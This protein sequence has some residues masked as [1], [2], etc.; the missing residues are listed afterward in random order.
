MSRYPANIITKNPATPTGPSAYGSAPGIWR[1]DEVA[2]WVKQGVWPNANIVPDTYFPYVSLLL[3]TTSLSNAN[4]NLFVD[5]SGAFNPI[6]RFGNTTQGS[7]SPYSTTWS[8]YF[9]GS[10]DWLSLASTSQFAIATSSTPFT[11][12]GWIYPT[13]A[14]SC[15]FTDAYTGGGD[16]IPITIS[17]S[18]GVSVDAISGRYVALG[19]F[20]GSAWV[21]AA[22]ANSEVSLNMWTHIACVFTG[23]TFKIYYNGVDV[24]AA[25]AGSSWGMTGNSGSAWYIGRRWDIA[26]NDYFTGYISNLRFVNGTA[27]YTSAFTPPTTPLTAIT[28]T[29]LLTCQSNRFRD[30]STNNLTITAN[31]NSSVTD[32]SPF[33]PTPP[34]IS[35]NQSDIT[36]W[37]GYFDGS[38][39]LLS[40]PTSSALG[41]TSD[42]TVET[43]VY[44][45]SYAAAA[46]AFFDSRAAGT[47]CGLYYSL[48]S[49]TGGP[50]AVGYA[51]NSALVAV[52]TF[53]IPLFAWTH[54]AFTR[55]G[56]TIT[57]YINGTS[58]FTYTD[59]R[60]FASSTNYD[61]G[62]S[63]HPPQGYMAGYRVV[64]GTAVYTGNF[65]PPT[66]PLTAV[67]GTSLLTMQ[68][69]AFTDRSTNNLV[70]SV[71][72]NPTV[73]GNSPFNTVGYWSNYFDGNADFLD[74]ALPSTT[75][76]SSW[77]FECW[78]YATATNGIVFDARPN[79][80]NGY[81]PLIYIASSTQ[82]SFAYNAADNFITISGGTLNRWL[83]VAVVKNGSNVS[84]YVNGTSVYSVS[85]SN[86]WAIGASRPRI[87]A[88]GGF[89]GAAQ[90]HLTG[91][92]SNLRI[93]NGTAVYT[94][95]FTPPT[96]P[97]TAI[98]GTLLL[99]CQANRL[100]DSSTN[101]YTIARTGDVSVQS[102]DPF[103]TSTIASNGG[104]MYFDGSGDYLLV[105]SSP[106]TAAGS[107]D[108]TIE[109]W[110][111]FGNPTANSDIPFY[112]NYTGAWTTNSIYWGKHTVVSGRVAFWINNYS[113]GG[114]LLS[115]PNY[116]SSAWNHYAVTRSGSTWRMFRDGVVVSTATWAGD[117][118]G[119]N[120]LVAIGR[121]DVLHHLGYI[122]DF[123]FTKAALYTATFTPPTAPLT[124]SSNTGLLVNG[125]NAGIYD[126]TAINDM[127]TVGNA[128]VRYPSPYA[129]ANYYAGSFD[130]DGDYLTVPANS[131]FAFG[132]GDF[133]VEAWVYLNAITSTYA[134]PIVGNS[135]YSPG[136]SDR[137]WALGVSASGNPIFYTFGS[138]GAGFVLTAPSALTASTWTHVAVSR[139]GTTIKIFVN[140]AE[141][142]S[143][144]SGYNED[145]TGTT[146]KV[147]TG[148]ATTLSPSIGNTQF[149]I[150]GVISNVRIVKGTAVYTSNFTPSTTPLTAIS[151]TS[152]LTCQNKTFIDNSSNAFTITAAG[153]ATAGIIGPFTSTGGTSVYFDGA[154]DYLY[155]TPDPLFAMGT[156]DFTIEGWLYLNSTGTEF[157]CHT[158]NAANSLF[159]TMSSGLLRLTNDATVFATSASTLSTGQW[160]HFAVVRSSGSSKVYI[161]GSGGTAVACT[162][163]FTQNGFGVG[164]NFVTGANYLNGYIDDLRV[165]KGIARYT[166]NFTPPTQPFVTY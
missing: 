17:L 3:S 100:V 32:F 94:S 45:T 18:N 166:S 87:G 130:G 22:K 118:S 93:V 28:N 63:T 73:T 81:Y 96:T 8:N 67:S 74:P 108:L 46:N 7:A 152:L 132:T 21:T 39:D 92:V 106:V 143:G 95:A 123:R 84:V 147:A 80:V 134:K 50:G 83:H 11:I 19:Y 25:G 70:L 54:I 125:M 127:E 155:R 102:F 116:P 119:T 85:D 90:N 40:T 51:T 82:I 148:E 24:T 35:Y 111:T 150:N 154:G 1:M 43:W 15:I 114:P 36:N 14:G 31:G 30:A 104:S 55:S 9:D 69:A 78:F 151:G 105:P 13:A 76:S 103:Y 109:C 2:Y 99:T 161:N 62:N 156:G 20:T 61:L 131:A 58:N 60:T 146:L 65:T 142:V 38:G 153:N 57:C 136:T 140:G 117:A 86:T 164:A 128:Q 42:W 139:S 68:D 71:S 97:L 23:S 56:N 165:T 34:G 115:D 107:S 110:V 6:S 47:G 79:G 157:I 129:P 41:L 98:S 144:T 121:A 27:V 163:D 5:S 160:Y 4:N 49:Y 16:N 159:V 59:T 133:T 89:Y 64:R 113:S 126:A 72:G 149:S 112:G 77:T 138:T 135:Y 120:G 145:W 162:V 75:L 88:N 52:S 10:G 29:V 91:Y 12:E 53:A 37:S 101:N 66:S 33:A 48:T 137:G 124:P 122:S 141:V 158:G 44:P 26:G